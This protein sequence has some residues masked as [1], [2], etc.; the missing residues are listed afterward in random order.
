[1]DATS[2]LD[3]SQHNRSSDKEEVSPRDTEDKLSGSCMCPGLFGFISLGVSYILL[4]IPPEH[5]VLL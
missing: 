1:M 2:D 3:S 5:Q 4:L